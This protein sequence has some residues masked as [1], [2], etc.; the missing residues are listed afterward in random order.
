MRTTT[1]C[2]LAAAV[3][4]AFGFSA[5][6]PAQNAEDLTTIVQKSIK[7]HG[8][9]D[10]LNKLKMVK[11]K[12]KGTVDIMG[13]AAKFTGDM[14]IQAPD[15]FKNK[16]SVTLNGMTIDVIEVLNGDKAWVIVMGQT[17]D[18]DGEQLKSMKETAYANGVEMLTPLVK[19][20]AYKLAPLAETKVE[21]K[22][23]VGIKVSSKG[24][25]DIELYFDKES[26]LLVRV[27]RPSYDSTAMKQVTHE[28]IYRDFKDFDG[29]K[30]PAKATVYH[31]GQKQEDFE[32]LELKPLDKIDP[33]EFAKNL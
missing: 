13:V 32:V 2:Q 28:T 27:V 21:G 31:D 1:T 25:K 6:V 24:H 18:V 12:V 11:A 23:A 22:P 8:G 9:E 4:L 14:L 33:N 20:K 3:A 10:A 29:I 15:K 30:Q 5:G 26:F 17:M 16:A 19:D 7:A